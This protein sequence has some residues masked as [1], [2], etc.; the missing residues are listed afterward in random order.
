MHAS[1][2][3]GGEQH[4]ETDNNSAVYSIQQSGAWFWMASLRMYHR[5]ALAVRRERGNGVEIQQQATRLPTLA[6]S[7]TWYWIEVVE[8]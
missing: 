6:E 1:M 8:C 4:I 7:R 5:D 2:H 3:A